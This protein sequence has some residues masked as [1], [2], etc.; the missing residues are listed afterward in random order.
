M[1]DVKDHLYVNA[2][3]FLVDVWPSWLP[4]L[5]EISVLESV[6]LQPPEIRQTA[7]RLAARTRLLL[8]AELAVSIPGLDSVA[9]AVA[10]EDGGTV[11][12][13]EVELLPNLTVRITDIPLAL[14]FQ[15]D[16]LKPVRRVPSGNSGRPMVWEVDPD[17]E[18]VEIQLASASLEFNTD[19]GITVS[20][21]LVVDLPAAM[22]ADTGVVI[23]AR[24]VGIHLDPNNPPLGQVVG[25]QGIS[26]GQASLS[27]PGELG[28]IVGTLQVTGATIG[29]GGFT[30]T[31]TD[32]WSPP[33]AAEL[34]GLQFTLE[35]V[36]ISFV[37][38]ALT[39]SGIQGSLTLP[40]FDEPLNVEVAVNLNGAFSVRLQSQSGLLTLH[41]ADVLDMTVES[42]GLRVEDG[43]FVASLSGR[44]TPLFGGL[45]WPTFEVRELSINSEGNVRLEGGW[46]D[47]PN[48]YSLDFYGFQI[49]ITRV[50]FGKTEDGGKWIGFSGGLKLVDGLTAGVS[51]EGLRIIWYDDGRP[52]K[53]TLNGIGVEF[54]VPD[55]LRFKGA[56]SYRELPGNVR[57]FD[58]DI[59]L[60]LT[61]LSLTVDGQLVIGYDA[62][63]DYTFFAFYLGIELP[64]GIQLGST[65]LALYGMA[66][67]FALNLEPDK[68]D[69]EEWYSVDGQNSWFHRGNPGV[70][71]LRK[72]RNQARSLG[73]GAGVTIG[74]LS[75]NGYLFSGK[76][77]LVIVFP[78]PI[79]LLDGKAN[80]LRERAAL[81]EEGQFRSLAVFDG[82]A[83]TLI[84]GVDAHY[85]YGSEGE[86]ID[87]RGGTEAFF[88]FYDAS[89]WHLYIG[90]REPREKRI[91]AQIIELIE[92]DAYFMMDAQQ[93]ATGAWAGY[94]VGWEFGPLEVTLEAWVEGNAFLNWK[95]VHLHG[96]YWL[97]GKVRLAV[98]GIGFGL[99]LDV[100]L[101]ADVFDPFHLLGEFSVGIELPWP[102]PD[103]E[104]SITLEWGPE[105]IPPPLPL[106]LK[107][108]AVEHLKVTTSWPLP[109]GAGLL[110]PDYDRGD[111]FVVDPRPAPDERAA[112][113]AN[114]P[115]VP[116]D[117]LP[118]I[119]FGRHVND[120]ALV[121]VNVQP[122]DGVWERIGDPVRNEGPVRI[123]YGLQGVALHRW[124][125]LAN[126]WRPVAR[127]GT[128]DLRDDG[129]PV[130]RD[131]FGSWAPVPA[132][133]NGGGEAVNQVKL[134][135]WSKNPFDYTRH[136]GRAWDEWFTDRYSE[137]PCVPDASDREICCDFESFDPAW[138]FSSPWW[139]PLEP[140]FVLSWLAPDRQS[141]TIQAPSVEGLTHALCFPS[142]MVRADGGLQPNVITIDLPE[143]AR[144][145]RILL[146][147]QEGVEATG[148]DASHRRYGP[149]RGGT[150]ADP[151]LEV[152]GQDLVRVE[153]RG[154]ARTCIFKICAVIAPDAAEVA[155]REE[156]SRHLQDEMIRWQQE[157]VVLEP[158]TAYRLTVTTSVRAEG[159]GELQW[160]GEQFALPSFAYF[161]TQ[162]PPGLTELSVPIGQN[163]PPNV[164]DGT[165][166]VANGSA[167]VTGTGT[168]W[169]D[170]LVGAVLQVNGEP[171]AY[172]IMTVAA[173]DRLTLKLAYRGPTQQGTTYTI[174]QF[175]SGLDDL[176][177][178]VR[179][180]VPATV[181]AD[182]EKPPLPRPV[183]RAYDVG[184]EFDADSRH[185]DLMYR[186]ARRDLGLYLYDSNN[187]PVRDA[188]GRLIVLSNRWG[189]TEQLTF[190]ESE[191]RWITIV[192]ASDCATL[193]PDI[194]P[195]QKTLFSAA[196]GQVLDPD[197][198]YEA[199]L[200]PL[201]LHESFSDTSLAGWEKPAS[202]EGTNG[203]PSQWE[204]RYHETLA[205]DQAAAAG[206]VV[207][208]D[209]APDL[210][211]LDPDFDVILLAEDTLRPSHIYRIVSVD[212]AAKT[213]TVDGEPALRGGSSAWEIPSLG[214]VVQTSDI[215]GGTL[216]G[217]DAVKP[218]TMLVRANIPQLPVDHPEQP[219]TWTDYR[220][221][222]YLHATMDENAMGVVFRYMDHDSYY[223]FSMDRQRTYR[224]LV[225]VLDG[226]HTILAEDDFV[227]RQNQ[228]YLITVEAIGPALR[229]YQDGTL[230]FE[231]TDASLD[232]GS[233][234]L[235][236]WNQ[237][238]ARFS[239]IRVDDFRM[240]APV[241]YRFQFTT[242][243]FADFF[244]HLH[245]YQDETWP[246]EIPAAAWSDAEFSDLLAKAARPADPLSD[247]ETRAYEA[248]A[249]AVLQG[250]ARQNPPEVQVTKV[251]RHG[252]AVAFLVQSPEPVDWKRADLALWRADRLIP[253]AAVPGTAKLVEA[254]FGTHQ[255][256]EESVTLLLRAATNLSRQRIESRR[257]PGGMA[258]P[259]SDPLLLADEFDGKDGGLLF[260]EAFGPNALNHYTIEDEGT[261]LGPSAW[262]VVDGHI[263][264]A[265]ELYG[266]SIAWN[267]PDK[268][269]AL[270]LVGSESW[271]NVGVKATLRS[272][273]NA[274]IGVVFRYQNSDHY[275]RF[276]MHR[277]PPPQ[278]PG[279]IIFQISYRR[280]IKK[281][282]GR[283]AVLWEDHV[284]Y[285]LD[286]SYRLVIEAYG[287]QLLGYL[288]DTLLF[289]LRDPDLAAGR[290]GFYCWRNKGAHFEDLEVESL[291][292]P[293]VLWQPAFAE[294][295]EVESVDEAGATQGPSQWAAVNGELS[296]ASN[297]HVVDNTPHRPGTYA[298]GGSSDWRDVQISARLR[299][300]ASGAIGIMFRHQ[301]GDNYYR[302][303]MD[304]QGNYRRLIKK[305]SG[306][307]TVLRQVA[308]QYT[309][310][311]S[312]AL[313][314]C[315]VGS[316]LRV[317]LDG[318]ELFTY[319]DSDLKR[320]RIG[321][322]CWANAGARFGDVVVAERS[323]RLGDWTVHDDPGT[324]RG[325]SVWQLSGGAL[326]QLSGIFG[327]LPGQGGPA[328][329]PIV[330]FPG[331]YVVAGDPTWQDYRVTVSLR[332]D[333]GNAVGVILRYVDEDN[334][335]RFYWDVFS[336]YRRL[337]KKQGGV[338]TTLWEDLNGAAVGEPLRLTIDAIGS[339]L[340]GYAGDARL[341]DE[342]DNAHP[343]GQIGLY[344]WACPGARFE[345]VEV[346]RLP[347]EAHALLR[348]RF[349]EHDRSG[350][351]IE[352]EGTRDG[353]SV[354]DF[355]EG[356]L[357][358]TS[359]I[360]SPTGD[361]LSFLGTQAVG[362]DLGWTD[363]VVSVRLRSL[364][365]GAIGLLFRYG[366][367]DN[368]Y[369]F[370]MDSRTRNH[371]LVKK[372][373]GRFT[374]LGGGVR[375]TELQ[376]PY[377]LTV[378]AIGNRLHGYL[379][380]V[381]IFAVEDSDL[382]DGRIGLYCSRNQD[383]QFS[384][385]RV[386]PG[387]LGFDD[388]L[389]D[390]PFNASIPERWIFVDEGDQ[391]GPS[392]W[393][394]TGGELRQTSN[395]SGGSTDPAELDKPGTYALAGDLGWTDYRI[396]VPFRS[397][398]DGAIGVMLRYQDSD[399]YYRFS[400]DRQGSY[401]RLIK[402]IDGTVSVLW[403]TGAPINQ[404]Q[405]YMLVLD[406][407]GDR[408]TGYLN[409][410]QLFS[411]QDDDLATGRVGLYCWRNPGARFTEVHVAP[412]TW[413]P[414]YI[415][416]PEARLPAGT[417]VRMFAGS[418]SDAPDEGEPGVV[419]RFMASLGEHGQLRL[420]TTGVD[421]R[422]AASG[423]VSGHM[424]TFLPESDYAP[425]DVRVLRRADGTG[426]FMV[427]PAGPAFAT[428]QYRL[429]MTYHRNNQAV[430]PDSQVL[431]E[432]GNSAP[433]HVTLDIP[434]QTH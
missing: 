164:T 279:D 253:P 289:S 432:A 353:P 81:N 130:A 391:E 320:G 19:E 266:G 392:R 287:D 190:T 157:G 74:T 313:T 281:T 406:C 293:P 421:L 235:Y 429:E 216:D 227:Y 146:T 393:E 357:R 378:T 43:L 71:D 169:S 104:A 82:R 415:F 105:P 418:R 215:W 222:V 373:R 55:V 234:G 83:G 230:V 248:L 27:L 292:V 94:S 32:T 367:R 233:V 250:P 356:A 350:W 65:G 56:V 31:I 318:V 228:D 269:G 232:C 198:I 5:P 80:L 284:P 20:T 283:V 347:V 110:L 138:A 123:R 114:E 192:N 209:G 416:G 422:L 408:L 303:S 304:R 182:G 399:H 345:Q 288:D 47:L 2:G 60:D 360:Y 122:G 108:I 75:D 403:E 158:H 22:I 355:A 362:G 53:F 309:V 58:G 271:D 162:G 181:P 153:L 295:S 310:G 327:M 231:V 199:R 225:R 139:H 300:D 143:P 326:K 120:D 183:Y 330:D 349:A 294:V 98:F 14:R 116:L 351:Q 134:W 336:P 317:Y 142:S 161:R 72:W 175:N 29:H 147:D 379:D 274:A 39:S 277:Y 240:R 86:M 16:L 261:E 109:A 189:V 255:P 41:K 382:A 352:D 121:G 91:R 374:L 133:P 184:V 299:S 385:L 410:L 159:E 67:L 87:I 11:I 388:W 79:I 206:A 414:Y 54:E 365:N 195:H 173:P 302:F 245:S 37:Q 268:P 375:D 338:V 156:M 306:V 172:R 256:N 191:E 219:I 124:E 12:P 322:Y 154:S 129:D 118:H 341:F 389:L 402:K 394:V 364:Q 229:L 211:Q 396:S 136:G 420:P 238:G 188:Q 384:N 262:A 196:E 246:G 24:D 135:L 315:A 251:E 425:V 165:I 34:F 126:A 376:R 407:M 312:Y 30:G 331:T 149:F 96:D 3:D 45:E 150:P 319:E 273:E 92:A 152:L 424:R 1:R 241:V 40:F 38:N 321:F 103:L 423:A 366:D 202:A 324:R 386:Y 260:R 329:N 297:I 411:A 305:V 205:G 90:E 377:Q 77:L 76:K 301:D 372:V 286:Q 52:T 62:D 401:W 49:E 6:W 171:E 101:A 370:S 59:K 180:T 267:M 111:G 428:G 4:E 220:F 127:K 249:A 223:R 369:R 42:L 186:M 168:N 144:A 51:V 343:A 247:D 179:Q 242:S 212:N 275:Y 334:Y 17:R 160:Y 243:Q 431:S 218:G 23:E 417:R 177:P 270:A 148:V 178:Y 7:S 433:E 140:G 257:F 239:D 63:N 213:V 337:S 10:A 50:G 314:I 13:V 237:R 115:V 395:I 112:P 254:T 397:D 325:P 400:M 187:R 107:E 434:W 276:S 66:G 398:S 412:P 404:G 426:F 380:D 217:D 340:V 285:N 308:G 282:G 137:Y 361:R 35:H 291:E 339:R 78:G 167:S 200:V 57:R 265:S 99:S 26:I 368:Y 155:R 405:L 203:G 381:P 387:G 214:A 335:Y 224:R 236:C 244:H 36:Q 46:L 427:T 348:D 409:G 280:L 151:H 163:S 170:A 323:R 174:S 84:F 93:L 8:Q 106:P 25:W 9:L 354:W 204:V 64:T 145:V 21:N 102:L 358:Q 342:Q 100:R 430:D 88:D 290:V 296:Q 258:E 18:F 333:A 210:A 344:C 359:G 207:R 208:L 70:A 61:V 263:V 201:L 194:I 363:V 419:R 176:T 390:D 97:H 113:P 264:Q 298:L 278:Q 226:T 272:T 259:S 44:L 311:Q 413:T 307:V 383:A 69:T 89:A 197:T 131:L 95:P 119:A 328:L 221:S 371:L 28:G 85:K 125:P 128:P 141:V 193:N 316:L 185:I 252:E 132:L 166:S 73:F 68:G 33:L 117:A 15:K 332:A 48:Q 346:R